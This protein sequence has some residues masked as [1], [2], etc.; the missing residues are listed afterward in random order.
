[1][2][3]AKTA[4]LQQAGAGDV[5]WS[6]AGYPWWVFMAVR[7]HQFRAMLEEGVVS[8]AVTRGAGG[9]PCLAVWTDTRQYAVRNT[10][11]RVPIFN[12]D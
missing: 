2:E 3:A 12:I 9:T 5:D 8:L 1:M 6:T 7:L 11:A 4:A 10:R